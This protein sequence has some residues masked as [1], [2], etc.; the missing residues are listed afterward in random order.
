MENIVNLCS[1][2]YVPTYKEFLLCRSR[3][4][5]IIETNVNVKGKEIKV[6]DAGGARSERRK[7][8]EIYF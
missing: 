8:Y 1:K 7:V 2:K 6:Y 5:G 4:T 3:T